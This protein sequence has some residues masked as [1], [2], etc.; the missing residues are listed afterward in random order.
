MVSL[1]LA[2]FTNASVI[3][4]V[5][6]AAAAAVVVAI[7]IVAANASADHLRPFSL[8]YKAP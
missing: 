8:C 7:M 5:A 4:A 6:A 2:L 3:A 1:R